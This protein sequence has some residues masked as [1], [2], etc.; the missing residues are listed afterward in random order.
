MTQWPW[1]PTQQ[2][3]PAIGHVIWRFVSVFDTDTF[4]ICSQICTTQHKPHMHTH[5]ISTQICCTTQHK[6]H[7]ASPHR[8]APHNTT[9]T[10]TH[11]ASPHRSAPHNTSH[12]QHLHTDLL[13]HTT[14]PTHSISTT[15]EPAI[16]SG[17]RNKHQPSL[18]SVLWHCW[19]GVRKSIR[20][21]NNWVMRCW[22]GYIAP[23]VTTL[24]QQTVFHRS[25]KQNRPIS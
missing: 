12:T 2:G 11:T 6:P 8:S 19:L 5:S 20:P 23:A 24:L 21:V 10:C 3:L 17:M 4:T 7:T 14:Q 22:C 9:H 15:A 16:R 18:P 25:S 1:T 13:H